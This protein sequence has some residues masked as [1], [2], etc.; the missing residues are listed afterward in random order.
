MPYPIEWLE[1]LKFRTD[2]VTVVKK[3]LPALRH[4]PYGHRNS[5]EY[6]TLCPFH[7]EK[8]ASF[9]VSYNKQFYH[10]FGCGAHGNVFNFLENF[11]NLT[12]P[13]AV[14]EVA[15]MSGVKLP[16]KKR[17]LKSKKG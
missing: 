2:I 11:K 12:F 4:T 10:C 6:K 13:E 17:K 15:R 8:T 16:H 5:I 1:D 14:R 7:R 9:F 3:Y